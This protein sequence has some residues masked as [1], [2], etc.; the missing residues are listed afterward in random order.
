M[1][2]NKAGASIMSYKEKED[3]DKDFL[4]MIFTAELWKF[5]A[6]WR[7]KIEIVAFHIYSWSSM[8][9]LPDPC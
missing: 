8:S 4:D 1:L 5:V 9:S 2:S 6:F 3:S 7:A